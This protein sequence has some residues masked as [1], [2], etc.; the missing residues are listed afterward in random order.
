MLTGHTFLD[1]AIVSVSDPKTHRISGSYVG[2]RSD[3][4]THEES[5]TNSK[6]EKTDAGIKCLAGPIH[7]YNSKV[8]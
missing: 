5:T 7:L 2:G 8:T 4:H 1:G 3:A 6:A